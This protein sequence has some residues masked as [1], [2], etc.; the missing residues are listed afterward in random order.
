MLKFGLGFT[1][2]YTSTEPARWLRAEPARKLVTDVLS[3][4][5]AIYPE[6]LSREQVTA[7]WDQHIRGSDHSVSLFR[8][9]TI[10]LWLQ[11]VFE[12]KFRAGLLDAVE[13][14]QSL[15]VSKGRR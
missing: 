6:L 3:N 8:Y 11:Q 7:E 2:P 13:D 1:D 4:P 5:S 9:L 14:E 12:K 15:T 10:E